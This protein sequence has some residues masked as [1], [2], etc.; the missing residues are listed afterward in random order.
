MA[1]VSDLLLTIEHAVAAARKGKKLVDKDGAHGNASL[2]IGDALKDL[3]KIRK[4]LMQDT[5]FAVDDRLI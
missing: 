2:A 3:E 4:R 5:Y 1:Q